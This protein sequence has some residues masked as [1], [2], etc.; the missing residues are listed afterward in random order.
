MKDYPSDLLGANA[1]MQT[2]S[3][4]NVVMGAPGIVKGGSGKADAGTDEVRSPKAG[5]EG[6]WSAPPGVNYQ[7]PKKP[8][9]PSARRSSKVG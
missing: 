8:Q 4:G 9:G 5:T 2:S 7:S 6:G 1:S 3:K